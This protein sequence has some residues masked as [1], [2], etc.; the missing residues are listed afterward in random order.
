[1]P[2]QPQGGGDLKKENQSLRQ[3]AEEVAFVFF[4]LKSEKRYLVLKYSLF[5]YFFNV[6][7]QMGN[8]T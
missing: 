7:P 3:K 8:K 6:P 5:P 4:F 1:M 2:C